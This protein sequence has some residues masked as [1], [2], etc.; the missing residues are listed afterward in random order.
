MS[1]KKI[2]KNLFIKTKRY[3]IRPIRVSDANINYK[4]W[5]DGINDKFIQDSKKKEITLGYLKEYIKKSLDNKNEIFLAIFT[6]KERHIGNIKFLKIDL[7]KK[8]SN[9][10]IW[11]GDKNYQKKGVASETLSKLINFFFDKKLINK[12]ELGV[13]VTNL[14]AIKLYKKL[15]FKKKSKI[16][17][18]L[19]MSLTKISFYKNYQNFYF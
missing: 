14:K 8:V 17:N 16:N 10:G 12:F 11:I 6:K 15:G 4:R 13:C 19:N 3:F 7:K 9:L 2:K 1:I 5:F 18:V